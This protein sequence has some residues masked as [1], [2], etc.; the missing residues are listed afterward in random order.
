M[1]PCDEEESE[2]QNFF[3]ETAQVFNV[4]GTYSGSF[5]MSLHCVYSSAESV[6]IAYQT[7]LPSSEA[8]DSPAGTKFIEISTFWPINGEEVEEHALEVISLEGSSSGGILFLEQFDSNLD[9]SLDGFSYTM[10]G[11][12]TVSLKTTEGDEGDG[13]VL[14]EAAVWISSTSDRAA[15][16]PKSSYWFCVYIVA[17]F[18]GCFALSALFEK[19]FKKKTG[20][21]GPGSS[22]GKTVCM[23]L[24]DDEEEDF[25]LEDNVE[26][27]FGVIHI[28]LGKDSEASSSD[29]ETDLDESQFTRITIP[30]EDKI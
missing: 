26:E 18:M 11:K 6:Q 4:Y 17:G 13:A 16:P 14:S 10:D 1:V 5:V 29:A 9:F 25:P 15:K 8:A 21:D 7:G 23:S 3:D 2:A 20:T 27:G 22:D 30:G 24:E 12:L 19:L 28:A